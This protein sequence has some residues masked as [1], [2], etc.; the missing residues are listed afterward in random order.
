MDSRRPPEALQERPLSAGAAG[1][2][3]FA[4]ARHHPV[5]GGQDS[6]PAYLERGLVLGQRVRLW[7]AIGVHQA[8][9]QTTTASAV[10][11]MFYAAATAADVLRSQKEL[12]RHGYSAGGAPVGYRREPIVVGTRYNGTSL[13]RV[14]WV[15][16]PDVAPRIVQAFQ[17]AL[18]GRTQ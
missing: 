4:V 2:E 6:P 7:P 16:D 11:T 14:R 18:T 5:H 8:W 9:A 17:M 12:A 3:W 13:T 15:P 1:L 10:L